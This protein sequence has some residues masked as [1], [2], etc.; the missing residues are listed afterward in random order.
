MKKTQQN[1]GATRFDSTLQ[2]ARADDRRSGQVVWLLVRYIWSNRA[3]QQGAALP[4]QE[5]PHQRSPG[6]A[7]ATSVLCRATMHGA[8][9]AFGRARAIGAA[10][11]VSFKKNPTVL[12]LKL[13]SKKD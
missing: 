11:S 5:L 7:L 2:V 13:H 3:T 4:R 9:Q 10:K 8:A 12:D 6:P 1:T